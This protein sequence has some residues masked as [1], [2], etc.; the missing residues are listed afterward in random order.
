MEELDKALA[1]KPDDPTLLRK[2]YSLAESNGDTNAAL[3][4]AEKLARIEPSKQ[5]RAQLGSALAMEGKLD[6][7]LAL[8]KENAAEVLGD[9]LAWQDAVRQLESE[10]KAGDLADLFL[11]HLR[12]NPN[13]WQSLLTLAGILMGSGQSDRVA[14]LLWQV[15]EMKEE[16]AAVQPASSPVPALRGSGAVMVTGTIPPAQMR[17]MR[18]GE[19]YQQAMQILEDR[20]NARLP[21]ELTWRGLRRC[22]APTLADAQT[23]HRHLACLAVDGRR[24]VP[25]QTFRGPL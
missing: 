12:A 7:A 17:Q 20:G 11:G 18:F 5:H 14:P 13:D 10:G 16:P 3:R 4:Y 1:G 23:G 21:P 15:V 2:L 24:R 6:E 9:P 19:K 8:I 25:R 22:A